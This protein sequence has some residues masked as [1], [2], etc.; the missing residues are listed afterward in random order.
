[1][2]F[3]L[4]AGRAAVLPAFAFLALTLSLGGCASTID[5]TALGVPATLATAAE[6]HPVAGD[7]FRVNTHAVYGLW[8]LAT[9]K[10]PSVRKILAGQ[11]L[12]NNSL[13]DVKIRIRSRW[14]DVLISALT[15]GLVV[16]RSVTVEGVVVKP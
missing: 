7:S 2:R 13:S 9:L 6:H 5:A 12:G 3:A 15:L 4:R 1:M 11:L 16:P 10:Q 14:S 8:G